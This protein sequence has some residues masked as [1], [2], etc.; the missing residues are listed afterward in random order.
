MQSTSN[1]P[2]GAEFDYSAPF[3]E[4]TISFNFHLD[5]S[6]SIDSEL[7]E[8]IEETQRNLREYILDT[9][10]NIDGL[11]ITNVDLSLY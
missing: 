8:D 7:Y 5:V 3:N 2:M 1:L 11:N 9:L 4:D 10:Y 6:G